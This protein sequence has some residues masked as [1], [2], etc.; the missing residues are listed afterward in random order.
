MSLKFP[1]S[2]VGKRGAADLPTFGNASRD[3]VAASSQDIV[4]ADSSS[5]PTGAQTW[6]CWFK[7]DLFTTVYNLLGKNVDGGNASGRIRINGNGGNKN[8]Q[9]YFSE[10][11]SSLVSVSSA[12][13]SIL[14]NTWYHVAVTFTPSGFLKLYIN[15]VQNGSTATTMTSIYNGTAPF[16]IGSLDNTQQYLDGH[17]ADARIYDADI[18]VTEINNLYNGIDYQTNLVG[19]W[20]TDEDDAVTD[21]AGTFADA[22]NNGSTYSTDSPL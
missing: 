12:A 21:F 7:T 6:C 1:V 14:V 5:L 19:W 3:F 9:A 4:V 15:G 20:L 17:I 8:L 18:G 2:L 11:G 10:D 22:T 13:N 16:C